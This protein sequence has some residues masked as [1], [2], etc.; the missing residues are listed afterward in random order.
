MIAGLVRVSEELPEFL[1][2]QQYFTNP[3]LEYKLL[4]DRKISVTNLKE[5]KRKSSRR[6]TLNTNK[7]AVTMLHNLFDYD[8]MWLQVLFVIPRLYCAKQ[9]APRGLA[10]TRPSV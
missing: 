6:N 9:A 2:E 3:P 8:F 1:S 5:N 7:D 4:M 10:A